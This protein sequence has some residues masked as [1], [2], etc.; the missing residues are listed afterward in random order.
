MGRKIRQVCLLLHK[1]SCTRPEVERAI[2]E[3][4]HQGARRSESREEGTVRAGS[5]ANKRIANSSA[6]IC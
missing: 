4:R 3:V 2:K 5:A 1:K 6:V